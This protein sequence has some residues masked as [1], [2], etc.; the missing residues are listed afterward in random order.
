MKRVAIIQSAY[1]PWKGFFDLIGRCDVYVIYDSVAFTKGYWQNRN[2]IKRARG[3]PWLTI[4]VNTASRLGQ[5]IDE[6][7]VGR[8]ADRHW[9]IIDESYRAARFFDAEAPGVK[10]LYESLATEPMLT[11][12][13]EHII[14]WLC[15]RLQLKCSVVRD[16]DYAFSGDRNQ[17]LVDLCKAVGATH[18]LS[19]PSAKEYLDVILLARAGIT[20]EWMNY[21]PYQRYEQLHGELA[22]DVSVLDTLFSI[23]PDAQNFIRPISE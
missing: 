12:I 9:S 5:P 17:K 14:R 18:Y 19:G 11:N 21:G 16:R 4:P 6:V 8:W 23:G 13:N 3:S 10:L 22:H 2:R 15:N 7:T 1:I 20:V